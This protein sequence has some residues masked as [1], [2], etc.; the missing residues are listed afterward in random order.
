MEYFTK[1][2]DFFTFLGH[3]WLMSRVMLS[4]NTS[5]DVQELDTTLELTIPSLRGKIRRIRMI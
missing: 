2:H 5:F 4:K 1:L 3:I